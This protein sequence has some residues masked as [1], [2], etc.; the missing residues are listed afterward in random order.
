MYMFST[1]LTVAIDFVYT[2]PADFD[3]PTVNDF[4]AGPE[5]IHSG[6]V[7]VRMICVDKIYGDCPVQ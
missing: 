2:S 3:Q 6:L 5:I 4:R 1:D 7:K